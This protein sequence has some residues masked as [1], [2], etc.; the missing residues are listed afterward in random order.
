MAAPGWPVYIYIYIIVLEIVGEN[1]RGPS[2]VPTSSF[3]LLSR[4]TES[5]TSDNATF[6]ERNREGEREG[7]KIRRT[8]GEGTAARRQELASNGS[9]NHRSA[10]PPHSPPTTELSKLCPPRCRQA[11]PKMQVCPILWNIIREVT[12]ATIAPF[13]LS[14]PGGPL[15]GMT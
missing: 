12:G 6:Q 2:R 7:E 13:A 9:A 4:P 5:V 8:P 15:L 3:L 14:R 10:K 1:A 11:Q